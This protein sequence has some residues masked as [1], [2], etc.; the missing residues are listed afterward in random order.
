[1]ASDSHQLKVIS[2]EGE[3]VIVIINDWFSTLCMSKCRLTRLRNLIFMRMSLMSNMFAKLKS[4]S[5]S[6]SIPRGSTS[7][8][9]FNNI[10]KLHTTYHRATISLYSD[11]STPQ[12]I[13]EIFGYTDKAFLY[14][15][16]N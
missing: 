1:M 14:I 12:H 4:Q 6:S 9:H 11:I 2:L 16:T 10:S 15:T 5:C 3:T 8:A 7:Y 13:K